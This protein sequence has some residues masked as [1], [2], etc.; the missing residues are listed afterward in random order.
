MCMEARFSGSDRPQV[1][2]SY[3]DSPGLLKMYGSHYVGNTPWPK[4]VPPSVP[5]LERLP[6]IIDLCANGQ[7]MVGPFSPHLNLS[8][9]DQIVRV[10]DSHSR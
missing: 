4:E 3:Q 8:G 9:M 7:L 2:H 1:L 5:G 10:F 6:G